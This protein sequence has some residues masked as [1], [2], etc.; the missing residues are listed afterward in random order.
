MPAE[1][2]RMQYIEIVGGYTRFISQVVDKETS[3]E[4]F[5]DKLLSSA[6]MSTGILPAGTVYYTRKTHGDQQYTTFVFE[7]SAGKRKLRCLRN[8]FGPTSASGV[9]EMY[10]PNIV[11]V[12]TFVGTHVANGRL[13]C[14]KTPVSV[15]KLATKLFYLPLP[16]Q[17]TDGRVCFGQLQLPGELTLDDKAKMVHAWLFDSI[18]NT[19]LMPAFGR[20]SG[21]HNLTELAAAEPAFVEQHIYF[22]EMC[23]LGELLGNTDLLRR[24]D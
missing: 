21:L 5:L 1:T 14:T 6:P 4:E 7:Y 22:T 3:T 12:C 10:L 17:Y 2:K 24:T 8:L 13:F 11:F 18:W 16:N 19:D 23:T 20:N 15:D 9:C